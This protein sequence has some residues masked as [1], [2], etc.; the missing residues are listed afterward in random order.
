MA[1]ESR[2]PQVLER[3]L[4]QSHHRGITCLLLLGLGLHIAAHH[5]VHVRSELPPLLLLLI[6][7][8]L[9]SVGLAL[10]ACVVAS[11]WIL[12]TDVPEIGKRVHLMHFA[13]LLGILVDRRPEGDE[14]SDPD[15][16]KVVGG[17]FRETLIRK[18]FRVP[19][20]V[21][22]FL[23]SLRLP[24]FD[25]SV[26]QFVVQCLDFLPLMFNGQT[27]FLDFLLCDVQLHQL[28]GSRIIHGRCARKARVP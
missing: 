2:C 24:V 16:R 19:R 8:T 28:S 27:E 15:S 20:Q 17:N 7:L 6:F 10:K 5:E 18:Y 3:R 4:L 13:I 23:S 12:T 9:L 11:A 1:D 25:S 26:F 22:V 21:A 14:I